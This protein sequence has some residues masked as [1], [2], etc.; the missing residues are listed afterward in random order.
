M[1]MEK[2]TIDSLKHL[3]TIAKDDLELHTRTCICLGL[4]SGV[5]SGGFLFWFFFFGRC[6]PLTN[7]ADETMQLF[8]L[9][10][11]AQHSIIIKME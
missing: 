8:M 7:Y 2:K 9:Y 5:F 3:L 6:F 11:H 4:F 10:L 1:D